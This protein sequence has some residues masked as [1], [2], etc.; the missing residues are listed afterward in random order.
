MPLYSGVETLRATGDSVQWGGTRLCEGGVFPTDSGRAHFTAVRP[1]A[2]PSESGT[3]AEGGT[4]RLSTRRGK[5]FNTI[6]HADRDPLT[7]A[8][9]DAL[10]IAPVDAAALG[11]ADG[12][13]V[14]VRSAHGQ[15]RARVH[16][17]ALTP[18]NVQVFFPEGNVLLAGG[19]RDPSG[20]PDYTA[21]VTVVA[22]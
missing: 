20:V 12:A 3:M 22:E 19:H 21:L 13:P 17:A 15:L 2:S 11:I 7:G 10:F 4:F 9:R 14:L 6:V 8:T 16:L 5:Q 18:G 1:P